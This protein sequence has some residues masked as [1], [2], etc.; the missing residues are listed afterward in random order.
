MVNAK[1]PSNWNAC[2]KFRLC[3]HG[4][5]D[6]DMYEW[7]PFAI[8][9]CGL[10]QSAGRTET[11]HPTDEYRRLLWVDAEGNFR[12][13][14]SDLWEKRMDYEYV[15]SSGLACEMCISGARKMYASEFK[16][17]VRD[18]G[19]KLDKGVRCEGRITLADLVDWSRTK[20]KGVRR[21]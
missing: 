2:P 3:S 6:F 1:I 10:M 5:A 18:R 9:Y 20:R 12:C 19:A 4:R 14:V 11:K 15:V 21:K 13:D 16:I 8:V 17:F 7:L